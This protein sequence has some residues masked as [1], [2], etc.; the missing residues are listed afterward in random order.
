M[1]CKVDAKGQDSAARGLML[2]TIIGSLLFAV[3]LLAA[4]QFFHSQLALAQAADS[5]VD[6]MGGAALAWALRESSRPADPEHPQGH[7]LA[8]PIAALVVAVLSGV[9]SAEVLRSACSALFG[10]ARPILDWPLAAA[11]LGKV[12]FK[13]VIMLRASQLLRRRRSSTLTALRVDARN[14]VLVC[15]LALFGLILAHAS[16]PRVDAVLAFGI[17]VYIAYSGLQLG[18]ENASLLLGES[19]SSERRRQL[20][21]TVHSVPGVQGAGSL[22]AVWRGALLHVQLNALVDGSLSLRAAHDLG[23]IVEQRLCAE[24]DVGQVAVHVEPV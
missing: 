4:H 7:A 13:S 16:L 3:A 22:V 20:L 2:A 24:P 15:S 5:L 6:M 21:E 18:R 1:E 14:D 19:A 9:L 10:A 17:A 23:H 11:F 8:Q 12:G